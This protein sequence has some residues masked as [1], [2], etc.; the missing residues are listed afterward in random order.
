MCTVQLRFDFAVT[1]RQYANNQGLEREAASCA[2][3]C[4]QIARGPHLPECL[5]MPER[6]TTPSIIFNPCGCG[7][8]PFSSAAPKVAR[9]R[10]WVRVRV[11]VRVRVNM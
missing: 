3:Q 2:A 9:V 5:L 1:D 8:Q 10:V 7:R 11:R 4:K 6:L